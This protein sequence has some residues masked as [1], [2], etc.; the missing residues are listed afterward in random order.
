MT[1]DGMVQKLKTALVFSIL[2]N[3]VYG[4]GFF[5]TPWILRDM[6]GGNP[7]E[8]GWIRWSG[9][10]LLALAVG[11]IQTYQKPAGQR[12]MVTT[13]T[14]AAI[15]TSIGLLYP[16]LFEPYSVHAWFIAMPCAVTFA[17]FVIMMRGQKAAKEILK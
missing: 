2:V 14:L 8:L 7:V 10:V 11:G 4:I 16:L 5:I 9:G 17:L 12:A 3:I 15:L 6:A 1:Q 13:L